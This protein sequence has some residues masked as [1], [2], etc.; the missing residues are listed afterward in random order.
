MAQ[1][2]LAATPPIQQVRTVLDLLETPALARI[3]AYTLRRRSVTVPELVDALDVPQGTAYEYV[4][5]LESADLLSTERS[6]RPHEYEAEPLSVTL[7]SGDE[8]RTI[9][10]ELVEAV[11][12]RT[13]D[14]DIDLYVDRH[15]IDGLASAL[16]YA[17]QRVEGSTTHRIA[18]R[19]LD[20]P[21][22]EAEII[23]QALEPVV[24]ES[25]SE[26]SEPSADE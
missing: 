23:L 18:A 26:E 2:S 8:T 21:P 13:D 9:T 6:S 3:Y 16:E 12:R 15:G 10:P 11:A 25:P 19:E 7:S 22:V 24:R 17:R 14:E 20:V 5:R 1:S 4:R